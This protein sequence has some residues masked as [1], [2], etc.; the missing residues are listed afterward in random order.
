MFVGCKFVVPPQELHWL[1]FGPEQVWQLEWQ[2]RHWI[3]GAAG[4]KLFA[5]HVGLQLLLS[6]R[7]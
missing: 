7:Y 6:C 3:E 5:S 1:E 2:I 4:G